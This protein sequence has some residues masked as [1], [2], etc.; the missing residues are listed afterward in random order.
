MIQS[1]KTREIKETPEFQKD[2]KKLSKKHRSLLQLHFKLLKKVL[3]LHPEGNNK[4]KFHLIKNNSKFKFIKFR[5]FKKSMPLRFIYAYHKEK[6]AIDFI[7][8]YSKSDKAN[9]DQQRM[10]KYKKFL[11]H[12]DRQ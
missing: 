2:F 5:L 4:N 9:H 6:S 1:K 3:Y 7:E 12:S 11:A 8:L 10:T